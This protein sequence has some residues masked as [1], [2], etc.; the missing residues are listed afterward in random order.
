[1]ADDICHASNEKQVNGRDLRRGTNSSSRMVEA[2]DGG[3]GVPS[4][5]EET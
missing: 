5:P 3:V 2:S 1:M 4:S